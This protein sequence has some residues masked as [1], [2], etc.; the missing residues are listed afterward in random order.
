[1]QPSLIQVW[2]WL[3]T[4]VSPTAPPA[5][6]RAAGEALGGVDGQALW[7]FQNHAEWKELTQVLDLPPAPEE[8]WM[9]SA[10]DSSPHPPSSAPRVPALSASPHVLGGWIEWEDQGFAC[11]SHTP[12]LGSSWRERVAIYADTKPQ[13]PLPL[14][15]YGSQLF[16]G[17]LDLLGALDSLN[18]RFSGPTNASAQICR[19]LG[20]SD[21]LYV[22][23][24][25]LASAWQTH[26]LADPSR[27][28][29]MEALFG[30][31]SA[32][33]SKRVTP[34]LDHSALRDTHAALQIHLG[35][36]CR[37]LEVTNQQFAPL[38]SQTI[39]A[40]IL[41]QLSLLDC[42]T[43]LKETGGKPEAIYDF[44]RTLDEKKGSEGTSYFMDGTTAVIAPVSPEFWNSL[45]REDREAARFLA[46]PA[47]A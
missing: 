24:A 2:G 35:R 32:E 29:M 20:R 41:R 43:V 15:H 44:M 47:N 17:R 38:A 25:P 40:L 31:V 21:R 16:W 26:A 27:W 4:L 28:D 10:F 37:L 1:M 45:S 33:V 7:A 5:D 13:M 42:E 36:W 12:I 6:R 19:E 30:W 8:E 11:P 3:S 39:T 23:P 34:W 9:A 22:I 14:S 18:H 46:L